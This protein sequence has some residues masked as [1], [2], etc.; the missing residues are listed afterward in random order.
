MW[1][2]TLQRREE[3]SAA[4][5]VCAWDESQAS[6]GVDSLCSAWGGD[7]Q[8]SGC[9][10]RDNERMW[11]VSQEWGC[12]AWGCTTHGNLLLT[13]LLYHWVIA[14]H[15]PASHAVFH[16]QHDYLSIM[17]TR[18][19][20]N[21]SA[22]VETT[23]NK[24]CG[25][26]W[27]VVRYYEDEFKSYSPIALTDRGWLCMTGRDSKWC[28]EWNYNC[29]AWQCVILQPRDQAK[30]VVA[31]AVRQLPQS[32]RIWMK[33]AALETEAKAR[34]KVFRKGEYDRSVLIYWI[35]WQLWYS[36]VTFV[37]VTWP[38]KP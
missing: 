28:V 2:N 35:V 6:A 13:T 4:A 22:F 23:A 3:G 33:A 37:F 36:Q 5:Q 12:L 7:G 24:K 8:A 29:V 15:D 27:F 1:H 32:V 18:Y 19:Y 11:G 16:R 9:K 34:K 17:W 30:A 26:S 10:E 14:T 21:Q 31:Q 38:L 20:W 25:C